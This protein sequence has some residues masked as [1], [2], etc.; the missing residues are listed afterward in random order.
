MAISIIKLP[1]FYYVNSKI[2][3][4]SLTFNINSAPLHYMCTLDLERC[5]TKNAVQADLRPG[6]VFQG[7]QKRIK[8][9]PPTVTPTVPQ[10]RH[11]WAFVHTRWRHSLQWSV[12]DWNDM[13]R[14]NTVLSDLVASST[15]N[16]SMWNTLLNPATRGSTCYNRCA[17]KD[18]MPTV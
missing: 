18:S 14:G 17:N 10:G 4:V 15:V 7:H 8:Q 5:N 6:L 13:A 2:C 1:K 16:T 12:K 9:V 3:V 11:C